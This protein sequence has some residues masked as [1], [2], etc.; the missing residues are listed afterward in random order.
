MSDQLHLAGI[1]AVKL[2]DRQQKGLELITARQPIR[3]DDL[4]AELHAWKLANGFRGHAAYAT[5]DWCVSDGRSVGDALAGRGLVRYLRGK[6]WVT[7][8]FG[9]SDDVGK[10]EASSQLGPDDPW[11]EGF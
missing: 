11:P 7:S 5:C 9:T 8:S 10:P 3:S 2:T 6:G 4:G 1:P